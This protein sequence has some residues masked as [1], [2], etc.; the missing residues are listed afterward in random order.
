MRFNQR[1]WLNLTFAKF[2]FEV[3]L[4]TRPREIAR[5]F[6]FLDVA[7]KYRKKGKK[8]TNYHRRFLLVL[9]C[10]ANKIQ[11][12]TRAPQRIGF[13]CRWYP[14]SRHSYLL[15]VINFLRQEP[16][17]I[18][19]VKTERLPDSYISAGAF[20][21]RAV[22][23]PV[24]SRAQFSTLFA[25]ISASASSFT[26]P[27]KYTVRQFHSKLTGIDLVGF[28]NWCLCISMHFSSFFFY[29][30]TFFR[31]FRVSTLANWHNI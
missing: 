20:F 6:V 18:S 9:W 29:L 26:W 22:Q 15:A 23:R 1:T 3:Y 21:R 30:Q 17:R 11:W 13:S 10:A 25:T 5:S 27:L 19:A 4:F 28:P 14:S 16:G 8:E 24:K 7:E 2:Q 12:N 31:S